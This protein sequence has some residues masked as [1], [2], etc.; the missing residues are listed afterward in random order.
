MVPALLRPNAVSTKLPGSNSSTAGRPETSAGLVVHAVGA[1]RD[2]GV[3]RVGTAGDADP[4][5]ARLRF[6]RRDRVLPQHEHE[7]D[8][9]VRGLT[10]QPV[11]AAGALPDVPGVH[12]VVHELEGGIEERRERAHVEVR[13]QE[14]RPVVLGQRPERLHH[15]VEVAAQP[16]HERRAR[17][18]AEGQRLLR[19]PG[20]PCRAARRRGRRRCGCGPRR[21]RRSRPRWCRR[22][23]RRRRAPASGR[24]RSAPPR[25]RRGPPGRRTARPR[26]GPP[27]GSCP[28]P[29]RTWHSRYSYRLPCR[30]RGQTIQPRTAG[31]RSTRA[32]R[33]SGVRLEECGQLVQAVGP[34]APVQGSRS[35]VANSPCAPSAPWPPPKSSSVRRHH[36][37]AVVG[38]RL[39]PAEGVGERTRR[40][41]SPGTRPRGGTGRRRAAAS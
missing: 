12:A 1:D 38:R 31:G 28:W 6:G 5:L 18:V 11:R 2:A 34:A 14:V 9:Q 23:G 27:G 41:P 33:C 21:R 37:L 20:R 39:L 3:P 8:Q 30:S 17:L 32:E 10:R 22:C 36:R 13:D 29:R 40:G 15:L 25:P 4:E 19:R 26:C 24:H 16:L 35:S 7:R